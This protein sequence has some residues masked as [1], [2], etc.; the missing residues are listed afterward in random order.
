M[1]TIHSNNAKPAG[2]RTRGRAGLTLIEVVASLGI[3]IVGILALF[4]VAVD[5]SARVGDRTAATVLGQYVIDQIRLYQ[6][7]IPPDE[8]TAG[9][10]KELGWR[11]Y[12]Y[13]GKTFTF[14]G[15]EEGRNF[16]SGEMIVKED[17]DE[18][19]GL[20]TYSRFEVAIRF[21][22]VLDENGDLVRF[23]NDALMQVTV[24]IRWPRAYS[25]EG[26]LRQNT[27]SFITYIRPLGEK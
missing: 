14:N 12:K 5:A 3:I 26:R 25:D 2:R 27:L 22:P 17:A 7:E 18:L 10:L 15:M 23:P 13:D 6:A 21:R 20:H 1:R 16:G 11:P 9:A 24:T 8:S 19:D 4:P